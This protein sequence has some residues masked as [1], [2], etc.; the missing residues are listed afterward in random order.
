MAKL[1]LLKHFSQT[2]RRWFSFRNDSLSYIMMIFIYLTIKKEEKR[3]SWWLGYSEHTT[4]GKNKKQK[5]GCPCQVISATFFF[6][7]NDAWFF[8]CSTYVSCSKRHLT[9]TKPGNCK[10]EATHHTSLYSWLEWW[11]DTHRYPLQ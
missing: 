11:T 4:W 1:E 9:L 8:L 6:K 2:Q 10:E 7:G 5:Q 3:R